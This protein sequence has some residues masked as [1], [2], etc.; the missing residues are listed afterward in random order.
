MSVINEIKEGILDQ[1]ST[2]LG[3]DYKKI[4][5]VTNIS[6]NSLIGS[7]KG[8]GVHVGSATEIEGTIGSRTMDHNFK[9]YLVDS[10]AGP[11]EHNDDTKANFPVVFG[12]LAH[13]ITTNIQ[14]NKATL[15]SS[16]AVLI[17][18]DLQINEVEYLDE[19]KVGFLEFEITVRY[20]HK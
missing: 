9:L 16:G 12:G 4:S 3:S 10:Y 8:Y 5:Y 18:N 20:K 7:F 15:S 6:K 1:M 14:K 2:T 11:S 19:E 17:V 13:D